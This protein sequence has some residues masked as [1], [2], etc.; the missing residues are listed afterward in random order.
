MISGGI[1]IGNGEPCPFCKPKSDKK[2]FIS[3]P[4]NNALEHMIEEHPEEFSK[5]LSGGEI[6]NG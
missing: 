1:A 5:A 3:T 2:V 6:L 4:E